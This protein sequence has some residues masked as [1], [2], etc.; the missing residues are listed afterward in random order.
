M[1]DACV[2]KSNSSG[3]TVR[4]DTEEIHEGGVIFGQHIESEVFKPVL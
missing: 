1:G 3:D 4:A 2:T